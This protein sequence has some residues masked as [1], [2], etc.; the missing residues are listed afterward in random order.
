MENAYIDCSF[1][2]KQED[3]TLPKLSMKDK[4]RQDVKADVPVKEYLHVAIKL[5]QE[6]LKV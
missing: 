1:K 5:T 4:W 3:E 6:S 2:R